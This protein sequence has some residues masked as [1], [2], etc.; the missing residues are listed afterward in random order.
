[1]ADTAAPPLSGGRLARRQLG[2]AAR[3]S[4]LILL[5]S[6]ALW[7]AVAAVIAYVLGGLRME[8]PATMT[9]AV[10][11]ASEYFCLVFPLFGA[12]ALARGLRR[13]ERARA[14]ELVASRPVTAATAV[15]GDLLGLAAC[16]APAWLVCVV[17]A[18]GS[19]A[20]VTAGAGVA[21]GLSA[22]AEFLAALPLGAAVGVVPVLA[23]FALVI[24]AAALRVAEF[25]VLGIALA[26]WAVSA[27]TFSMVA[28]LATPPRFDAVVGYGAAGWWLV[29]NR[30]CDA[31]LGT[32]ALLF[33][34]LARARRARLLAPRPPTAVVAAAVAL[35]VV[36]LALVPILLGAPTREELAAADVQSC[37]AAVAAGDRL[38]PGPSWQLVT[39]SEGGSSLDVWAER[40]RT[41]EAGRLGDAVL[42]LRARL[43][44]E[45]ATAAVAS[46]RRLVIVTGVG[47]ALIAGDAL[48]VP[49]AG[50]AAAD[51]RRRYA[52]ACLVRAWWRGLV[53][54]VPGSGRGAGGP[55]LGATGGPL[56]GE[57]ALVAAADGP[58]ALA[59]ELAAW[60]VMSVSGGPQMGE[61]ERRER[62]A[63]QEYLDQSG[64]RR[65]SYL[66]DEVTLALDVWASAGSRGAAD[67]AAVMAVVA[68]TRPA[69]GDFSRG[70]LDRWAERL[71]RRLG[72]TRTGGE[73]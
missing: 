6:P 5:R 29:L 4:A 44:G 21:T 63:A 20:T 33:A 28:P 42:R 51:A 18:A 24:L 61:A 27:L 38:P 55:A 53:A 43:S 47:D 52:A 32:S 67:P 17:V 45:A 37:L 65:H 49:S 56:L 57:W 23:F 12:V 50:P 19:A 36:A 68:E 62:A 48:A 58:A 2:A 72:T 66:L 60:R 40:G 8:R 39:V 14:G 13:D 71:F 7:V 34:V 46:F 26:L 3:L 73:E 25:A 70:A 64:A 10:V 30:C 1:M 35:L 41:A 31:A 22:A 16:L 69:A 9:G 15:A 11:M 54:D 59:R